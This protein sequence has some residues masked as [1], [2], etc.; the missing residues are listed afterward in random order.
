MKEKRNYFEEI[1]NHY[2][3]NGKITWEKS[4]FHK[5]FGEIV[6]MLLA[7]KKITRNNPDFS[8]AEKVFNKTT[9]KAV[10]KY[11]EEYVLRM[12]KTPYIY[13]DLLSS[14]YSRDFDKTFEGSKIFENN[15]FNRYYRS[16]LSYIG[17]MNR[18]T[19]V[20]N[21]KIEKAKYRFGAEVS[22]ITEM[23]HIACSYLCFTNYEYVLALTLNPN[24]YS[25]KENYQKFIAAFTTDIKDESLRLKKPEISEKTLKK[26][27]KDMKTALY[28]V[29]AIN[30]Y[31]YTD[32]LGQSEIHD[33]ANA[34]YL[35]AEGLLDYD[36]IYT[37]FFKTF[38]N[39]LPMDNSISEWNKIP[40]KLNPLF[41]ELYIIISE[42]Y[43]KALEYA[44]KCQKQYSYEDIIAFLKTDK[45]DNERNDIM[46]DF[47]PDTRKFYDALNVPCVRVLGDD[48]SKSDDY[49]LYE[50]GKYICKYKISEFRP[51]HY[52]HDKIF[53]MYTKR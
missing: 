2:M 16:L 11:G 3:D 44:Y 53:D 6:I 9:E 39:H 18:I 28:E 21:K 26:I 43:S 12:L 32:K 38:L 40:Q 31:Y 22:F 8:K 15:L 50:P 46:K 49:Y 19:A 42:Y 35:F 37:A 45:F 13:E 5:E 51:G 33:R 14:V 47:V 23:L 30:D 7:A 25:D 52:L 17:T 34:M 4:L 20:M 10:K 48:L 27:P 24:L 36:A 41:N 29:K 1:K